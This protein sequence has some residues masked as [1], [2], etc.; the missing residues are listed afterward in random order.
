MY[1]TLFVK[2]LTNVI[3]II[4]IITKISYE[5]VESRF[6]FTKHWPETKLPNSHQT[7]VILQT[8]IA[9]RQP[10]LSEGADLHFPYGQTGSLSRGSHAARQTVPVEGADRDGVK[11]PLVTG[12]H[13]QLIPRLYC[14][15][16][17]CTPHDGPHSGN[18]IYLINLNKH[19]RIYE[20]Q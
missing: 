16:H 15:T 13:Q 11:A 10:Y 18:M 6:P 1:K 5:N 14:S 12:T 3:I 8:Y 20:T 7:P 2:I 19:G 17:Y 9:H 4:I